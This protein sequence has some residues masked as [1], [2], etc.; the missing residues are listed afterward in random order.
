MSILI[1][2]NV[3]KYNGPDAELFLLVAGPGVYYVFIYWDRWLLAGLRA[4]SCWQILQMRAKNEKYL[5][6]N[7]HI[8]PIKNPAFLNNISIIMVYCSLQPIKWA[9]YTNMVF[10]IYYRK[11]YYI[12]LSRRIA[13]QGSTYNCKTLT[14]LIS[15]IIYILSSNCNLLKSWGRKRPPISLIRLS[16][17]IML[18][19]R[20][21]GCCLKSDKTHLK[22]L[23]TMKE[24]SEKCT[25]PPANELLG[26][27]PPASI[28]VSSTGS[29]RDWKRHVVPLW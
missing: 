14:R 23:V 29:R 13:K 27:L 9:N 5:M 3:G 8:F 4:E 24:I 6:F 16:M 22:N 19:R 25:N 11:A 17:E 18:S 21:N 26:R 28:V 2:N 20:S 7:W 10:L 12:Q 15:T 1:K